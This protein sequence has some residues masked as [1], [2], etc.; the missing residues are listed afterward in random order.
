MARDQELNDF[1]KLIDLRDYAASAG[2]QVDHGESTR[3]VTVMR[4]GVDKIHVGLED[5]GDWTWHCFHD[6]H[7][8]S[9]IDFIQDREGIKNLGEIR[10]KLRPWIGRAPSAVLPQISKRNTIQK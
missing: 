5:T 1:V 6:N 2:Y 7:G 4:R 10:K 3:R 8:G 9:I